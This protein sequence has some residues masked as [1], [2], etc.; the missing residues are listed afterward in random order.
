MLSLLLPAIL[1]SPAYCPDSSQLRWNDFAVSVAADE[2]TV[3]I[4]GRLYDRDGDGR[5]SVGDLFHVDKARTK[6]GKIK[7]DQPWMLIDGGLASHFAERF[8]EIGRQ[9]STSCDT[10]FQISG[11]P[12]VDTVG[13]LGR[14]VHGEIVSDSNDSQPAQRKAKAA[15]E[16]P[17]ISRVERLNMRMQAWST[18]ICDGSRNVT[19][20]E[21]VEELMVRT[22]AKWPRIFKRSTMQREAKDVAKKF[23]LKCVRFGM[24]NLTF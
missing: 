20:G 8:S 23:S 18:E 19:E 3:N 13:A 15:P 16:P 1:A 14:F 2:G 5:P 17:P 11:V 12:E 24:K 9:L 22:R 7:I 6:A 4:R 21:L 10:R